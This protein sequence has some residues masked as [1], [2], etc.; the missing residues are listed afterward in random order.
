M[1]VVQ[2]AYRAQHAA[3]SKLEQGGREEAE[4]QE[5][6]R[7]FCLGEISVRQNRGWSKQ[8]KSG[9]AVTNKKR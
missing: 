6:I 1:T 9:D 3:G 8:N 7:L 5:M 2:Y 4:L